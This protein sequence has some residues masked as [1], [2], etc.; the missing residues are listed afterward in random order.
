M[1]LLQVTTEG[2]LGLLN[3][4][5]ISEFLGVLLGSDLCRGVEED[6]KILDCPGQQVREE[7]HRGG[8]CSPETMERSKDSLLLKDKLAVIAQQH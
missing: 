3:G 8:L 2:L 7:D 5:E 6:S 1:H 4:R